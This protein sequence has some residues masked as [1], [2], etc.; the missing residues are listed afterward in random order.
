VTLNSISN[1]KSN[2]FENVGIIVLGLDVGSK[3]KRKFI[4]L[5]KMLLT[6]IRLDDLLKGSVR[7]NH[8]TTTLDAPIIDVVC[9]AS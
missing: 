2:S 5:T 6:G 8:N 4:R 9:D 7:A 1:H 3:E